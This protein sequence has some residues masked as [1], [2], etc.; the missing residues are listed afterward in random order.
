MEVA[1][2]M[3]NKALEDTEPTT[4]RSEQKS[5]RK[6]ST[7]SNWSMKNNIKAIKT[8]QQVV[9]LLLLILVIILTELVYNMLKKNQPS[10]SNT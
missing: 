4:H 3:I 8:K 9:V 6:E 7:L 1:V 10:K 2:P 5:N